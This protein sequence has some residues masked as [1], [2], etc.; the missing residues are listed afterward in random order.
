MQKE[1][2]IKD[3]IDEPPFSEDNVEELRKVDRDLEVIEEEK[4]ETIEKD[5]LKF[6][7][8]VTRHQSM[9]MNNSHVV[10]SVLSLAKPEDQ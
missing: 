7:P 1:Q 6:L 4:D 8:P 5:E 2:E 3:A 10:E 9:A